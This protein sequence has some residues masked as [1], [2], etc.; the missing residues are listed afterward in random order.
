MMSFNRNMRA[1]RRANAEAGVS[2]SQRREWH[3]GPTGAQVP[4]TEAQFQNLTN[5]GLLL[6]DVFFDQL[7]SIADPNQDILQFFNMQ[8]ST[9]AVERDEG[10]GGFSNIPAYTGTIPY[11]SFE[12]LYQKTY[13]PIEFADGL[14]VERKLVDDDRY[15]VISRRTEL[16]GMAYDRTIYADATAVFSNAFSTTYTRFDNTVINVACGDGKALC[17]TDHPL[18]PTNAGTQSNKG[19]GAL[20]YDN[21]IAARQAMYAFTDSKGNPLVSSPDVLLVPTSLD[22]TADKILQSP[23]D[24][25]T[26]NRA[27][28]VVGTGGLRKVMSRY[29]TDQNDWFL[30]D[31]RLAGMY[32]NWFWRMRPEF[33]FDP[34]SVY[35]L[36]YRYRGYM[37]YSYGANAWWWIYG[38]SVA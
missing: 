3:A 36:T 18:S 26:A 12:Q 28:N 24:P 32:L 37:R 5:L 38:N 34:T 9:E 29:L 25:N 35:Q 33:E 30:I 4:M 11:Q 8:N 16:F 21:V 27:A 6:R 2:L 14:A 17:A 19:T 15:N 23:G 31:S 10:I 22:A 13:T 20:T 7:T 1:A